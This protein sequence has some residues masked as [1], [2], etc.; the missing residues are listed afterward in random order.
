MNAKI[1]LL[2]AVI[3]LLTISTAKCQNK[4]SP[5]TYE[6]LEINGCKRLVNY[7][8][9]VSIKNNWTEWK[10]AYTKKGQQTCDF[11]AYIRYRKKFENGKLRQET[12]YSSGCDECEEKPCGVWNYYNETGEIIK[13]IDYGKCDLS[14]FEKE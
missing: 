8:S 6:Y 12:Q 3:S 2:T 4:A 5:E 11:S 9:S 14:A 13:T 1:Y 7:K 10:K